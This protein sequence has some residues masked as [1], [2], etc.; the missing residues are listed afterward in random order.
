MRA[1]QLIMIELIKTIATLSELQEEL[2]IRSE[3][4]WGE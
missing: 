3:R 2:E 4:S 1:M